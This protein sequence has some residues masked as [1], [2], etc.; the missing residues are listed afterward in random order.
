MPQY[1]VD[2]SGFLT[3]IPPITPHTSFPVGRGRKSSE[4]RPFKSCPVCGQQIRRLVKHLRKAH[5]KYK[6]P[7]SNQQTDVNSPTTVHSKQSDDTRGATVSLSGL[8]PSVEITKSGKRNTV[9]TQCPHCKCSVRSDRLQGHILQ[10]CSVGRKLKSQAN[11]SPRI[12]QRAKVEASPSIDPETQK[13]SLE[14]EALRQSFDEPI[15]GGKYLGHMRRE[16]DGK[17][18]SLPLYDDYEDEADAD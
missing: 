4:L 7:T 9:I 3:A 12:K 10:K 6:V 13:T 2:E 16:W 5:P 14:E 17:F 1:Y 8:S 18:G 11:K 15:Y